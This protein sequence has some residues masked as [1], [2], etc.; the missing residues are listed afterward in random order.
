MKREILS[1]TRG[2]KSIGPYSQAVRCQG[3]I[4]ISGQVAIDPATNSL[5]SD[6]SI[7]AQTRRVLDN[8]STLLE[9]A[10][11]SMAQALKVTVYLS[12]LADFA[13]MNDIYQSFF[14]A[15][16]PVRSTVEVSRLPRDARV[17]IDVIAEA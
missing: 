6:T 13:A 3:L 9:E 2:P 11:S 8:I 14:P 10:G 12:D 15:N 17:E 16:P 7:E 4:F 1:N 5:I